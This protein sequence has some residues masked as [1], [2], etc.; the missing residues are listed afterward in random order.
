MMILDQAT[1]PFTLNAAFLYYLGIVDGKSHTDS[2][3]DIKKA[4]IFTL[5]IKKIHFSIK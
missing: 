3:N 5:S 2:V 1:S 4:S